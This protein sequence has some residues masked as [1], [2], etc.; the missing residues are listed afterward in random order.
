MERVV[1]MDNNVIRMR[2]IGII[3]TLLTVMLVPS[4][5]FA[6]SL[7]SFEVKLFYDSQEEKLRLDKFV[8]KPVK[9]VDQTFTEE[10]NLFSDRGSLTRAEL[11]AD[12][13]YSIEF[14]GFAP[15]S[16][17][18]IFLEGALIQGEQTFYLPYYPHAKSFTIKDPRGF[19]VNVSATQLAQCNQNNK[20]EFEQGETQKTCPADCSKQIRTEPVQFSDQTTQ[21]LQAQNGVIRDEEGTVLLEGNTTDAEDRDSADAEQN[22]QDSPNIWLLVG[23]IVLFIGAVGSWIYLTFVREE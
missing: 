10:Y 16:Q 14:Q 4:V 1:N 6:D 17:W 19:Q 15:D 20:C 11:S 7:Q 13:V 3:C 18:T 23:G 2:F 5:T 8:D 22:Q 21:K 9:K 12:E